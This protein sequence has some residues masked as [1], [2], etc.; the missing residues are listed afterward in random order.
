MIKLLSSKIPVRFLCRYFG[1]GSSSYYLWLKGLES[2]REK[3][4]KEDFS[5]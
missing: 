2:D 4:K 3:T 1:V 5:N